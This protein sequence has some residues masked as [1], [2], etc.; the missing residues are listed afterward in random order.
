MGVNVVVVDTFRADASR[1]HDS[2]TM[3]LPEPPDCFSSG[4]LLDSAHPLVD[5]LTECAGIGEKSLETI[6][7]RKKVL[8][9]CE[10]L[11]WDYFNGGGQVVIYD[12]NNGRKEARNALAQKFS[13]K[14][15]VLLGASSLFFVSSCANEHLYRILV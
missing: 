4:E 3:Q 8:D 1:F 10:Q 5:Y 6:T 9:G 12:A 2:Q 14:D 13:E 11:I 7:L 15:I